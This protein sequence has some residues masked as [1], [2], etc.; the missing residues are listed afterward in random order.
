MDG[1]MKENLTTAWFQRDPY[2][3]F[4][5][6]GLM[7]ENLTTAWFQREPYHWFPKDGLMKETLTNG[8]GTQSMVQDQEG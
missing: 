2:H 3:W 4:P 8:S 5:K 6:D 1:L 7:K